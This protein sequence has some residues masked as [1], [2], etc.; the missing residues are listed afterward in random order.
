MRWGLGRVGKAGRDLPAARGW[1]GAGSRE[2]WRQHRESNSRRPGPPG[3]AS[4]RGPG[5][6]GPPSRDC[7]RRRRGPRPGSGSRRR[8]RG[9]V[10]P[11]TARASAPRGRAG[12][13]AGGGRGRG[14]DLAAAAAGPVRRRGGAAG[15]GE[16][17]KARRGQ[18]PSGGRRE[19][20]LSLR[21]CRRGHKWGCV[22]RSG[23][24]AGAGAR[25]RRP[26]TLLGARAL[27]REKGSRNGGWGG[28]RQK[29]MRV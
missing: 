11:S 25:L 18:L 28:G 4:A 14:G 17:E 12:G 6:V 16:A 20:Q 10:L 1:G 2:A 24:A 8:E 15:R 26:Q 5:K 3:S 29:P 21:G 19:M 22:G 9:R 27:S 23:A 13:A 7:A